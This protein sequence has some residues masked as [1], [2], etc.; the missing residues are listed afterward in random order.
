MNAI[1]NAQLGKAQTLFS[2]LLRNQAMDFAGADPREARLHW[3]GHLLKRPLSSFKELSRSEAHKLING[4]NRALGIAPQKRRRSAMEAG[5]QGRKSSAGNKVDVLAG[6]EDF[7]RIRAGIERLGWDEPHFQK[8]LQSPC[9]PV[10]YPH[11]IRTL[12]DANRVWW[13][14]KRMLIR[15]GLWE[16]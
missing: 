16:Q 15:R 12:A 3:A 7:D 9:S 14:I 5:T 6:Q 11:Q 10:P 8:W 13:A 1:S 2:Q 4:L